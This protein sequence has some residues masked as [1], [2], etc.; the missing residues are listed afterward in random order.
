M[1]ERRDEFLNECQEYL[2]F[3]QSNEKSERYLDFVLRISGRELW[4]ELDFRN[5]PFSFPV[6]FFIEH[7]E[8]IIDLCEIWNGPTYEEIAQK[9]SESLIQSIQNFDRELALYN[10]HDKD[11]LAL[12][13]EYELN[14]DFIESIMKKG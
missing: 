13:M 9:L 8:K 14:L 5:M 2:S 1:F 12:K 10:S 7:D 11:V 3:L 6:S 4:P